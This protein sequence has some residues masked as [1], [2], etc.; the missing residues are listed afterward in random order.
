ME[1]VRTET[2]QAQGWEKWLPGS[3]SLGG[4]NIL[5]SLP[6]A[7]LSVLPSY[8]PFKPRIFRADQTAGTVATAAVVYM[9]GMDTLISLTLLFAGKLTNQAIASLMGYPFILDTIFVAGL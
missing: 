7:R 6:L 9:A 1:T 2:L 5:E 3:D 4:T 8:S